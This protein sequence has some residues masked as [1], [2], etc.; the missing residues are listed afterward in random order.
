M[1]GITS[2]IGSPMRAGKPIP[3]SNPDPDSPSRELPHR[4]RLDKPLGSVSA[5][6][7]GFTVPRY[8][9]DSWPEMA[10]NNYE[11]LLDSLSK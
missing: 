2:K 4:N 8:K 6:E 7:P 5:P 3:F 9:N 10:A 11:N 1:P